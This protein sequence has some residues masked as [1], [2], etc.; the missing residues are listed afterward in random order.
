[1]DEEGTDG[2]SELSMIEQLEEC[3]WDLQNIEQ[4]L[5]AHGLTSVAS[6]ISMVRLELLDQIEDLKE[7]A[8]EAR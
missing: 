3:E 8:Q 2:M 7:A 5:K 4:C 6:D 1:L